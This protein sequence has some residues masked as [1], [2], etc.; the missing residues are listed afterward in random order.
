MDNTKKVLYYYGVFLLIT[1]N[2]MFFIYHED[3]TS[4]EIIQGVAFIFIVVIVY[5]ALVYLNYKSNLGKQ[6]VNWSL[7]VFFIITCICF[8]VVI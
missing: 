4:N 2:L 8:Y 3:Y 7:I 6:I 5:F 1:W